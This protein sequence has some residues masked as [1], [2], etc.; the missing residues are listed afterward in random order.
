MKKFAGRI[1]NRS[2]YYG[3]SSILGK[4][5]GFLMLPVYT[6]YLTPKDYGVV[7][8]LLL[9][10]AL[11]QVLLGAN[12]EQAISK[13]HFDDKYIKPL[14]TLIITSSLVTFCMGAIPFSFSLLYSD[15]I[16][17][18]LFDTSEYA[19]AVKIAS[20]NIIL[21]ILEVYGLQYVR[22]LDDY[23]S[24]LAINIIKLLIQL[25][26]NV[27][28][29][30]FLEL[31]VQGV[32][33]SSVL[34]SLFVVSITYMK[35]IKNEEGSYFDK[36]VVRPLVAYS[37][38]LW[39]SGLV[40]FYT[41]SIHQVFITYFSSLDDLGLYNLANTFGSLV[42]VLVLGPFFQYWQ[43]ERYRIY[44]KEADRVLTFRKIFYVVML[45]GVIFSFIVSVAAK[46]VILIM[47]NIQFHDS[48]GAVAPLAL[49]VAVTYLTWYLNFSF[50][51]TSST[52]EIAINNLLLAFAQTALY[53][54][55]IKE[56]GF[57]GA[58]YSLLGSAFIVLHF[59]RYRAKKYFDIGVNIY[60][61][62]ILIPLVLY[63]QYVFDAWV[64]EVNNPIRVLMLLALIGMAIVF[65][66]VVALFVYIKRFRLI[67][68]TNTSNK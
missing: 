65:V 22:I 30:V 61:L 16:S 24:Y 45:V 60:P 33:V 12:F 8:F 10:I 68:I 23:K 52:K 46:P 55:V 19:L 47:A 49:A 37:I 67:S 31:G 20:F 51:V 32:I 11:S 17:L 18:M 59:V 56:Y 25:L 64:D 44:N 7:G 5:I 62:Y 3:G 43:V 6:N 50:L 38:P 4:A 41:G 14:K 13:Y 35:L 66:L 39:V 42:S 9:F 54:V 58:A 63:V 29:V 53:S 28:F 34:G 26:S 48:A 40:G 2:L 36:K 1:L 21:G 57:V 15:F 27:Y